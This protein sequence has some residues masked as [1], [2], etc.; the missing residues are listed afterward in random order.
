MDVFGWSGHPAPLAAAWDASVEADDLV[1]LVG[2]L[3]WATRPG[4][5]SED[6]AWIDARPGRKILLKGRY[7]GNDDFRR[8]FLGTRAE[9]V[10]IT[11][12]R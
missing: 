2:D 6:L 1:L 4:E 8:A 3:S 10:D 7:E 11:L 5:V 12:E 9:L